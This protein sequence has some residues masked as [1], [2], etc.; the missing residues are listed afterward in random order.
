MAIFGTQKSKNRRMLKICKVI[1]ILLA[2]YPQRAFGARWCRAV[3]G[4][5]R[6]GR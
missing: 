5:R 2:I 4:P 3:A 6:E 1:E